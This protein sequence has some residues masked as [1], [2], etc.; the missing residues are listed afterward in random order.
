LG[1]KEGKAIAH[2]VTCIYCKQKFDRDK[3]K[4]VRC[5][6]YRRYAHVDCAQQNG[7]LVGKEIVDPANQTQCVYC[8]ESLFKDAADTIKLSETRFAHKAC[9]EKKDSQPLTE[10]EKLDNY[11]MELY[12][13][14]YILP[15]IQKQKNKFITE[16]NFTYSGML[17]SLVYW[18]EV[19]KN[20]LNKE[21]MT[22]G[23]IPYIYKQSY[24]YYYSLWEAQQK[25]KDK[26]IEEYVPQE[27]EITIIPPKRVGIKKRKCFAFLD[28]EV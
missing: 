7:E 15:G 8:N 21:Q 18:Y 27:E 4:Y 12:D 20:P 5:E 22:L 23:I 24:D 1:R 9:Q 17:K 16:Y 10:E 3:I 26:K 25:N 2:N 13:I 28:E 19:K 6:G 11:I 14:D